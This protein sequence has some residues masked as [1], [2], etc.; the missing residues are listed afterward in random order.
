MVEQALHRSCIARAQV[1]AAHPDQWHCNRNGSIPGRHR[2]REKTIRVIDKLHGFRLTEPAELAEA[3][4]AETLTYYTFPEEHR[5]R[6]RTNN[7]SSAFCTRS[8]DVRVWSGHSPTANR[9]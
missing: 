8:G 1:M 9:P 5:R 7:P 2:A 3:G 6:I 4:V